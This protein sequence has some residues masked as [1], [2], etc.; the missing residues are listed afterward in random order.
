[1]SP[2]T[3]P[4]V[5]YSDSNTSTAGRKH[6]AGESNSINKTSPLA[7]VQISYPLNKAQRYQ[8]RCRN[9][10]LEVFKERFAVEGVQLVE[11]AEE[12]VCVALQTCRHH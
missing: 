8:F 9:A 5:E 7:I 6:L 2:A 11:V 4:S 10:V 3:S 12:D 1:M